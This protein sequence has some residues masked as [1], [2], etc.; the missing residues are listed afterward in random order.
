MHFLCFRSSAQLVNLKVRTPRLDSTTALP[1][2]QSRTGCPAG[3]HN[4][5]PGQGSAACACVPHTCLPHAAPASRPVPQ[6]QPAATGACVGTMRHSTASQK[7]S[8][9][10]GRRLCVPTWVHWVHARLWTAASSVNVLSLV[11]SQLP[12][13]NAYRDAFYTPNRYVALKKYMNVRHAKHGHWQ[14]CQAYQ[15]VASL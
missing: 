13:T 14:V 6:A 10:Q 5:Q 4:A 8:R 11:V 1:A 3:P 12:V 9:K 2:I 15:S 7:T